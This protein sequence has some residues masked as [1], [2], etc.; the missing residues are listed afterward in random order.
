MI[1]VALVLPVDKAVSVVYRSVL[2]H[3]LRSGYQ[4]VLMQFPDSAPRLADEQMKLC[5]GG[6]PKGSGTAGMLAVQLSPQPVI[7]M[8]SCVS[9]YAG[10]NQKP[11]VIEELETLC[12]D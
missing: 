1:K 12:N 4:D 6:I 7:R 8:P 9:S 5:G 2:L 3:D 10:A 11:F